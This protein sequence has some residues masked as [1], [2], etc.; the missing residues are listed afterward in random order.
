MKKLGL[1]SQYID[2][3]LYSEDNTLTLICTEPK[4]FDVMLHKL[5]L[6][7]DD[8]DSGVES[9]KR[10][11]TYTFNKEKSSITFGHNINQAVDLLHQQHWFTNAEKS[12]ILKLIQPQKQKLELRRM[13][14]WIRSKNGKHT[15]PDNISDDALKKE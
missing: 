6:F 8:V 4:I 11:F 3:V 10:E 14:K 15:S 5:S 9:T 1:S 2:S 13:L 12:S 7:S